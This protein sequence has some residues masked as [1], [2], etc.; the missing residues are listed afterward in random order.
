[1]SRKWIDFLHAVYKRG[2]H[3]D[4][5]KKKAQK[6]NWGMERESLLFRWLE[7]MS[8]HWQCQRTDSSQSAYVCDRER[9]REMYEV[10]CNYGSW[11]MSC[12]TVEGLKGLP[13]TNLSLGC[14]SGLSDSLVCSIFKAQIK[15]HHTSC[16]V[17]SHPGTEILEWQVPWIMSLKECPISNSAH[18]SYIMELEWAEAW[19]SAI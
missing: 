16:N 14:S 9:E 15:T 8:L 12:V 11:D 13:Y 4:V 1:M 2:C 3:I 17:Y 5:I 19:E 7:L 18:F 6:E 10:C